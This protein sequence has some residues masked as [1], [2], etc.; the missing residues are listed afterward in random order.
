MIVRYDCL[1]CIIER[2][3]FLDVGNWLKVRN[4]NGWGLAVSFFQVSSHFL[5]LLG[6]PNSHHYYCSYVSLTC[7]TADPETGFPSEAPACPA[8]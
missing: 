7:L 4:I 5:P 8:D 2:R 1:V 3:S 6:Y